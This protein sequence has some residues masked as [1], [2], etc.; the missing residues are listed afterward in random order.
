M[1]ERGSRWPSSLAQLPKDT[2]DRDEGESR[3]FEKQAFARGL[4]AP[5]ERRRVE[6]HPANL[7]ATLRVNNVK[8]VHLKQVTSARS[9]KSFMT[10]LTAP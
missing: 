9:S 3:F 7:A 10:T 6:G 4:L 8:R 1:V 2:S 5:V